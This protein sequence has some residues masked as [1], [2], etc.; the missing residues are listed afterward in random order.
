VLWEGDSVAY[1]E[2]P[3]VVAALSAS[4]LKVSEN[5]VLGFGVVPH[6][7]IDI[8]KHF[9]D[10][11]VQAKPSVVVYQLS[12]W[13]AQ[14]AQDLQRSSF[15]SYVSKI[16]ATGAMLVLLSP[17]PVDLTR[18]TED[19]SVLLAEAN[20]LATLDPANIILLDSSTL[21]GTTYRRDLDGDGI[22]DRKVDGVHICPEGAA[23]LGEWLVEQLGAHFSGVVP[24][25]PSA[26]VTGPWSTDQRYNNP[27]GTCT[28]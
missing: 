14:F 20:R 21:W 12:N 4:G 28:P 16:R 19:H 5:T 7:N 26:W 18:Q 15:D 11:A 13:D 10:S 6:D 9:T 17:P 8:I 3:G 22:P 25:P 23:R 1:D 2:A 24:V 27:S